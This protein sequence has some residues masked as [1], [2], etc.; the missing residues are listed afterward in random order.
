MDVTLKN[1]VFDQL[2]YVREFTQPQGVH[3]LTI[4][5]TPKSGQLFPQPNHSN[6]I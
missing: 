4:F 3:W 1:S 6:Q 2:V 5:W